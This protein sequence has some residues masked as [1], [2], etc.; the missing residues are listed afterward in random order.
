MITWIERR[1]R[2]GMSQFACAQASGIP[3]MKLSLAETGQIALTPTEE[4]TVQSVLSDY[5]AERARDF[6]LLQV[7]ESSSRATMQTIGA[8][9]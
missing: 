5:I 6:R 2:S 9:V 1:K 8:T 7:E 4:S 3:R